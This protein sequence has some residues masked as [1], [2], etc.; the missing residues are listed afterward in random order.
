[1]CVRS[2]GGFEVCFALRHVHTPFPHVGCRCA[3]P[4]FDRQALGPFQPQREGCVGAS[5]GWKFLVAQDADPESFEVFRT[6]FSTWLAL[7]RQVAL[8]QGSATTSNTTPSRP[9]SSGHNP[10]P[11]PPPFTTPPVSLS[12]TTTTPPQHHTTTPHHNTTT[13]PQQ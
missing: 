5:T 10:N 1:M 13:Q 8:P 12:T 7:Q 3:F 11:P 2:C 4:C 9:R 6:V